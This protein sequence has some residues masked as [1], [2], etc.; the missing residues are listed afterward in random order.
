M[1]S[2][3][4]RPVWR[5][6]AARFAE[7]AAAWVRAGGHAAIADQAGPGLGVVV[8]ATEE[9]AITAAGRWSL[10]AIDVRRWMWAREG[11]F[12]G[13][14]EARIGRGARASVLDWCV[15]DAIFARPTR[16]LRLD[17]LACAACCRDNDVVLEPGDVAR[18][19]EAGRG[20]L[21]GPG[22]AVRGPDGRVRLV[23]APSGACQHLGRDKKCR[24]YELR[25]YNCRAFP[26]G[27]EACLAARETTLGL[28]DGDPPFG[29]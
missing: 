8:G 6:F 25:P 22:R 12:A 18:F 10:L 28:R 17:C 3:V 15:R 26:A 14:V 20:E 7:N 27:S 11:P 24:I 9:G 4:A 29:A 13:L 21:L 2:Y 1:G 5:R 16:R 19:R 23:L